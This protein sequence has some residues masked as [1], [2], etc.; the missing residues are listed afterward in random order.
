MNAS[1][2]Q[3]KSN[4]SSSCSPFGVTGK[5]LRIN[6]TTQHYATE[7]YP[8]ELIE[9]YLGGR[10]L[11]A[12]YLY[13][14][15]DPHCDPL[16]EENKLIFMNGPL[17]GTLIP[18]NNKINVAFKSPLSQ[19]YSYSLSGGHWGPELKNAGYDGLILEGVSSHPVY[20]KIENNNV[21]FEDASPL[22]GLTIPE[23]ETK[24]H[25]M[26][27]T[28][29]EFQV[30][31]IG[32]AGEQLNKYACVTSGFYR[33]FGRGGV[34]AVLGSKK[35]KAIALH[36]SQS[37][38]VAEPDKMLTLASTLT[39]NLR[40]SPGGKIRRQYGTPEMVAKINDNG[41]WITRNFQESYFAEGKLLEGPAMREA[42][43]VGDT[44]CFACP[45][46]CGKR[47]RIQSSKFGDLIME[48]PEF[49]TIGMLGS[50]CGISDWDTLLMATH[51]CDIYGF[52]T[53][54]A[55][56]C[57]AF[58]MECYENGL[59]PAE[60]SEGKDLSFGNTK[61]LLTLLK[62]IADRHGLGDILAEGLPYAAAKLNALQY[63][64]HSKGQAFAVYD[65][66]GCKGMALTYATSP[67]GAHHMMATTMGFEIG[68]GTR[69]EYEGKADLQRQHQLSM[70][71]VDS[72]G[73]CATMRAG[74]TLHDQAHAFSVV[75]GKSFT[76]K[77]LLESAE[78]IL[79]LERLY[80]LRVGLTRAD[81]A[82]PKRF[83]EEPVPSG[84]NAGEIVDLSR[85]LDEFYSCMGWDS[86]GVPQRPKLLALQLDQL[87]SYPSQI[88][89]TEE[90]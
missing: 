69:L 5:I 29:R 87:P 45:V 8:L 72:L 62:W 41:F 40:A 22:W 15:V 79:N 44:S 63:A 83:L 26:L 64:M 36:G 85:M 71:V 88:T 1:N 12:Y 28:D 13:H 30:A 52:D 80:N 55:G 73:L 59:I 39:E 89:F 16:G 20:L 35:V 54:N 57:V 49:E 17:A 11:S 51:I 81:D 34:G 86:S 2:Q 61:A 65:P 27:G 70:A 68:S 43:V 33:E 31:V 24:V 66:R 58:A 60:L 90:N 38:S 53:I 32:P 23:T 84:L 10:G 77:D 48:G 50:N 18:G 9:R 82:L 21:T 47:S 76:E 37:F 19:S 42:I 46:A 14:E 78:R 75:T 3:S 25:Q 4:L 67:K 7:S 6:L 56:G 74:I